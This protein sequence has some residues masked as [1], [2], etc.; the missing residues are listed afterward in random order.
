MLWKETRVAVQ[1]GS[2]FTKKWLKRLHHFV[3]IVRHPPREPLQWS[4]HQKIGS[5]VPC[6]CVCV[7]GIFMYTLLFCQ[8]LKNSL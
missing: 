5:C 7:C 3:L 1:L 8:L 2:A 4:H 6:V